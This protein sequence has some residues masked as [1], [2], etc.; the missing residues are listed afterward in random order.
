MRYRAREPSVSGH[1]GRRA[2][3]RRIGADPTGLPIEGDPPVPIVDRLI[4]VPCYIVL[5]F[6]ARLIVEIA[7]ASALQIVGLAWSIVSGGKR[8]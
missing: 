4:L 1:P 2:R 3:A 6:A 7:I 8:T 5:L